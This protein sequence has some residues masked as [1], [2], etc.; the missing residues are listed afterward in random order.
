MHP[1]IQSIDHIHINVSDR[2]KSETW[3]KSVLGFKRVESLKFWASDGGP[4]MLENESKQ[5]HF[6]LFESNEIQNT[7]IALKVSAQGLLRWGEHLVKNGINCKPVNHDISWSIYFKDPDGNPFEITTYEF[8]EFE[9]LLEK[10]P[11][12]AFV[13]RISDEKHS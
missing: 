4:L 12:K 3:Y 5:I 2:D 6:A 9:I 1:R 10:L 13:G 8:Q 11:N 7:T